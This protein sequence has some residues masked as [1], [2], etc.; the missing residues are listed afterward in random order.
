MTTEVNTEVTQETTSNEVKT[1]GSATTASAPQTDTTQV[2]AEGGSEIPPVVT[3]YAPSFKYKV[4]D[5]EKEFHKAFH[6][7]IKDMETEKLVREL[8]EKADGLDTVKPRFQKVRD[9]YN[10]LKEE[11][12]GMQ[13]QIEH[14]GTMIRKGDLD[15]FFDAIDLNTNK[16]FKWVLDKLN[17][18]NLPP[19]QKAA[20][21][22]QKMAQQQA[23]QYQEQ[24]EMLQ[25]NYQQALAQ[26][27]TF[28]LDT[29]L[30]SPEVKPIADVYD[31]RLGQ[32]GAFRAEVVKAGIL[33]HQATGT[34]IPVSE[35][36]SQVLG[37]VS[38]LG[39]QQTGMGT[40]ATVATNPGVQQTQAA[41]AKP[42]VIPN[43]SGKG[44]SPAKRVVKSIADL[45]QLADQFQ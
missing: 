35:A 20:L 2:A 12:G 1:E 44:N 32:P 7:I 8:Y 23:T 16:V 27:R 28:E 17:Y 3:P 14:L 18:Q 11:Y 34:D 6:P 37:T 4:Y 19:E 36:V 39:L 24:N 43:V 26:A 31:A 33:A 38:R 40:E 9:E 30:L 45:R 41:P 29:A 21:D 22:Q 42:P 25:K 15:S 10:T 13:K 5:Q